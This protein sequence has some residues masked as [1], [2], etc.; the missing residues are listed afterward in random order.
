MYKEEWSEIRYKIDHLRQCCAN[1][2]VYPSALYGRL[3][4]AEDHRLDS[5]FGVDLF[6]LVRAVWR[7]YFC[8]LREGAS[9]ISMQLIRVLSNRYEP[10]FNR[11][12]MEI[13]LAI[14]LNKLLDRQEIMETYLNIAYFGWNMHGVEQAIRHL[15]MNMHDL[16]ASD[17][18]GLIARLKYPEPR[19]Y[20]PVRSA[21]IAR[22]KSYILQ[23]YHRLGIYKKYG[24]I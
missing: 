13:V 6:S 16:S 18:A 8:G 20:D 24:W 11:K 17:L 9:T 3:I 12:W 4:A 2:T 1:D 21:K 5:H 14:K 10:T 7:T 22:R 19:H 23:R 15:E